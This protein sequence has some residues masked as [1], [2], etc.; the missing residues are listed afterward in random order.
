MRRKDPFDKNQSLMDKGI[1]FI[2]VAV[3]LS[4]SFFFFYRLVGAVF[5]YSMKKKKGVSTYF[6]REI[7]SL[8]D[9]LTLI[10]VKAVK[11]DFLE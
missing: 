11:V 9:M 10:F 1:I 2:A 8:G 6:C 7:N 4:F 5:L 3:S